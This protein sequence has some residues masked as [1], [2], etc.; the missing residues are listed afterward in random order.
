M[1]LSL[2]PLHRASC[3]T[4]RGG[5]A[6]QGS[7]AAQL[8]CLS[9]QQPQGNFCAMHP[10]LHMPTQR[11]ERQ[12]PCLPS[13]GSSQ[14]PGPG[15]SPTLTGGALGRPPAVTPTV[16]AQFPHWQLPRRSPAAV[17]ER[18]RAAGPGHVEQR[19]SQGQEP[20]GRTGQGLSPQALLRAAAWRLSRWRERRDL[21]TA[22]PAHRLG[23]CTQRIPRS[24]EGVLPEPTSP[25]PTGT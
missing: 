5:A 22:L 2:L 24:G 17:G 16:A 11:G 8:C 14:D 19:P 10:R 18:P 20:L 1:S 7:H 13:L 4:Q 9:G 15:R 21:R 12:R 25:H 3:G 23:L 6:L